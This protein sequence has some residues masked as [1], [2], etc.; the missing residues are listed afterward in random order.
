ML[1]LGLGVLAKLIWDALNYRPPITTRTPGDGDEFHTGSAVNVPITLTY[2]RYGAI[3]QRAYCSNQGPIGDVNGYNNVNDQTLSAAGVK[4][5]VVRRTS[6]ANTV[7]GV[8]TATTEV[9]IPAVQ[10]V[11]ADGSVAAGYSMADST[12]FSTFIRQVTTTTVQNLRM[13]VAGVQTQL[14]VQTREPLAPATEQAAPW[15]APA[16]DSPASPRI[17][18]A[19]T[20]AIA[21]AAVPEPAAVPVPA[22]VPG[23][24]PAGQPFTPPAPT[25]VGSVAQ[26]VTRSTPGSQPQIITGTGV[27]VAAPPALVPVTPAEAVLIGGQLVG[28]PGST[29][30]STPAGMAAELGRL[31]RKSELAL[32][33]IGPLA[34]LPDVIDAIADLVGLL[35][36]FDAGGIYSIRPACGTD[37]NGEPLP[38]IEVPIASGLGLQHAVVARLDAIAELI[39][40]HKQLRQPICKGKPTGDPVTVT[41]VAVE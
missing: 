25:Q 36:D 8:G 40:H 29:P 38:P 34:N 3:R 13:T 18:P 31:E 4:V 32:D 1:G 9:P 24:L 12:N 27:V 28:G 17:A 35:D 21:P 23:G 10:I 11:R 33:K 19:T 20:P 39:D 2:D 5:R 14:T 41:G 26:T 30:P 22:A 15:F 16:T 6:T 7:C 37:A